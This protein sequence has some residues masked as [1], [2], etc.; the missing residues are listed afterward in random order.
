MLLIVMRNEYGKVMVSYQKYLKFKES[1]FKGEVKEQ[2][3]GQAFVN[4]F[5]KGTDEKIQELFY[6]E[7]SE[8]AFEF[9]EKYFIEEGR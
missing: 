8:E 7:D 4:M 2:R 9:I 1:F 6:K 5:L 3:V